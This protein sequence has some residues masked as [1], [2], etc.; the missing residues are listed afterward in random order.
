MKALC[1]FVGGVVVGIAL[2]I[3]IL[4]HLEENEDVGQD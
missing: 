3:G 1:Y 4:E 2:F